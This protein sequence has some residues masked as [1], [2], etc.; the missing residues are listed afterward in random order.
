MLVLSLTPFLTFP[1]AENLS[2][3][4]SPG[5]F[6]CKDADCDAPPLTSEQIIAR[7]SAF[8]AVLKFMI[9]NCEVLFPL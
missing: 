3:V 6:G 9:Q 7:T 2:I 5:I 4:L 1:P 8:G